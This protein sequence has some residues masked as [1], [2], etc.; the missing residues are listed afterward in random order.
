[1]GWEI[2]AAASRPMVAVGRSSLIPAA[3]AIHA[4]CLANPSSSHAVALR[5]VAISSANVCPIRASPAPTSSYCS[6]HLAVC[7][8]E[9]RTLPR[10]CA[11]VPRVHHRP[12]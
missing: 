10:I 1:V 8:A 4:P 6:L 9:S 12:A 11:F 3:P 5:C 2:C 7:I